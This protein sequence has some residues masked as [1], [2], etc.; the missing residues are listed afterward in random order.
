MYKTRIVFFGTRGQE[1]TSLHLGRFLDSGANIVGFVEAPVGSMSTTHAK[2]DPNEGINEAASR[3]KLPLLCP[4]HP[5]DPAFLAAVRELRPE[6]IIVNGYQFYL[7]R[8]LLEVPPLGSINFHAS[9]LPRHA[10]M[11]PVFWAIWYGDAETGMVVHFMDQGIDTGDIL[12]ETRVPVRTGDNVDTLYHRI[13]Q[14]SLP[15]VDRLLEDLDA[16]ALPRKPQ[17]MSRY[18]YNYEIQE[19]DWEL[20]FRQPAEVLRGRVEM[21]PGRFFFVLKGER[22]FV[23][24]CSVVTEPG[25]ARKYLLNAP[26]ALRD[27]LVFATPRRFLQVDSVIKG[28]REIDPLSLL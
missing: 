6:A 26:F 16:R 3:L 20:D 7:A 13:F 8:E 15:L 9:L 23:V 14:T 24:K 4:T 19:K 22:Y 2:K 27:K 17:D 12:Y 28:D 18:F 21:A 1:L 10:G 11:H 25:N 5:R